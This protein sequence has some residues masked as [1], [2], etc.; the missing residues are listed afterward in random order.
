MN[1]ICLPSEM[2]WLFRPLKYMLVMLT[3]RKSTIK[4]NLVL[5]VKTEIEVY[6]SVPRVIRRTQDK[7]RA[8]FQILYVCRYTNIKL[9]LPQAFEYKQLFHSLPCTSW[10]SSIL[11]I[12]HFLFFFY[13]LIINKT[14][15]K[16]N[17][18]GLLGIRNSNPTR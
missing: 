11:T 8:V 13:S 10:R 1:N 6:K 2:S 3:L 4:P 18:E 16:V 7:H 5:N 15:E 12:S 9:A 17:G 14:S